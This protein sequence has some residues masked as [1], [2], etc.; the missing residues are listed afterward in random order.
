MIYTQYRYWSP[1]HGAEVCRVSTANTSGL[2]Y[3]VT[4]PLEESG[5]KWRAQREAALHKLDLA[6]KLGH[7][8]GEIAWE[9]TPT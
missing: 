8:P 6:M 3:F 5:R 2:E 1:V 7:E 9:E 4:V